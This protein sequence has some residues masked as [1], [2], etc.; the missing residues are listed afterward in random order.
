[1]EAVTALRGV[2]PKLAERLAKLQIHHTRDLLFHLPLRYQDRT[3]ITPIAALRHHQDQ[4]IEGTLLSSTIQFGRRRSLRCTVEDESGTLTFRLFHFNKGQQAALQE[5]RRI[6]CFGTVRQ[7]RSGME[8]THPEYQLFDREPPPLEQQLTPIYPTTE[9]L[10][11]KTLLSLTEQA[12]QRT[13]HEVEELLPEDLQQQFPPLQEALQHLH[14][15]AQQDTLAQRQSCHDRIALEELLAHH[16]S[17]QQLRQLQRDEAAL[18]LR[19]GDALITSFL[20]QL[21]FALTQAQ[22]RVIDEIAGDLQNPY[23]MQRLL[24]GDVG[25]GKTLV[26]LCAALH[27]VAA[28]TQCALMAPTELLAA[29][30]YQTLSRQLEPLGI[31]VALL[32]G[33]M[34]QAERQPIEA[35]LAD[36]SLSIAV[37]THA[38]FQ[39]RTQFHKLSL[40]IIDEQHRFGVEQRY[41]LQQKGERGNHTP[42]QLVMTATP[43]PRTLAM[44][45][46]ADLD[47]SVIDELPP[48]RT[49]I[50]T[51]TI[52]ESRRDEVLQRV[53]ASCLEGRQV[54]WVCPL[55]E[56]SEV[57]ECQAATEQATMLQQQLSDLSIG[58]VHGQ[59][60]T[61]EKELVMRQFH[62]GTLHI[63]VATTVIEV[64]VDVPNASLMIIENA[65]RLGLAQLHQLRGRVGRGEAESSCV[66][67]YR[68]PLSQVAKERLE[69]IRNSNDGFEI[70][71]KDLEMRG[72]GEL[73]GRR[74]TGQLTL[75]F[76][77]LSEDQHLL[78]Q[79]EQIAPLLLK[80]S[81]EQVERLIQRWIPEGRR[82]RS[83]G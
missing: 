80:Q 39:Q 67:L 29:Q 3:R 53:H 8:M 79:V 19:Q 10:H 23:P 56:E 4:L 36:G 20:Q 57:L 17:M 40:V 78:E 5:G 44:T 21:P 34:K 60:K 35:G 73:L 52:P 11:Q 51:A 25:A 59:M 46:Y 47:S 75:R 70:A 13:L 28:N 30:H 49:P 58:L 72:P 38:L 1:M 50:K 76:A 62:Q 26:A 31:S 64:G 82:F 66:L 71:R 14:R 83:I 15:P 81:P 55:V 12:L 61:E 69:T 48:G 74:Q 41:A 9:G 22:Q 42:H 33:S 43:I 54:Y 45:F 32:T 24:Q 18:P 7:G 77:D 65:E 68:S 37:G 16:L 63:L 27:A 6:R 2:G